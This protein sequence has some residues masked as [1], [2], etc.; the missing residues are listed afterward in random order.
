MNNATKLLAFEEIVDGSG[1]ALLIEAEMPSGGRPRQLPVRTVLLGA[2]MALSDGRPAQLG[3]FHRALLSL[4]PFEKRRLKVTTGSGTSARDCTYRQY[5]DTFS[6]IVKLLDP[7]PVPAFR[8]ESSRAAVLAEARRQVASVKLR[9]RLDSVIDAFV[10]ASVPDR[11]K[12]ASASLAVDWTD[13]ETWSR[14]RERDDPEPANDADASWG[15]ATRNAPGAVEVLFF[16][17]Y[18]QVA[19]M[20]REDKGPDV[21]EL[22]R[23]IAFASP[24]TDPAALMARTLVRLSG[25]VPLGDVLCDCGY[26]HRKPENWAG[27]LRAAG[28]RLVMDLHPSDRT[29]QGTFEGAVLATGQLYCPCVPKAL[30]EIVAPSR[31]A[32]KEQIAAHD[33]RAAERA[34][35]KLAPL[36]ATDADGYCRVMCPAAAGKLRCALKPASLALSAEHPTV[37]HPPESGTPRCCAQSSITVPPQVNAKTRQIHDYAGPEHRRSY[38]RRTSAERTFASLSDVSTSGIHR[39]WSRLFGVAKNTLVYALAVVARNLRIVVSFEKKQ[40]EAARRAEQGKRP[41]RRRY[42]TAP[43]PAGVPEERAGTG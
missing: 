31:S 15:H 9:E 29:P 33:A 35:Y 17:F 32:T 11:Y 28:A 7:S 37:A 23:R 10:E 20:V 16:G 12:S 43:A 18:A 6:D 30:L 22:V 34:R 26:S 2:L 13:Y 3:F 8:G 36:S 40:S 19:T 1:V 38:N 21:P 5:S 41:R 25:T 14:P 24:V 42:Q 4:E 27:P 39:G